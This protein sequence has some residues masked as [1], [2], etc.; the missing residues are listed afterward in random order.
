MPIDPKSPNIRIFFSDEE[1]K[2]DYKIFCMRLK[3]SM[4]GRLKSFVE[5][6]LEY[7]HK[8]G[9]PIDIE[10][11][12]QSKKQSDSEDLPI[13]NTSHTPQQV[14]VIKPRKHHKAYKDK[15]GELVTELAGNQVKVSFDGEEKAFYS[16]ELE[17]V[18]TE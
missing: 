2:I 12:G 8:Y 7:W 3:Q 9:E 5:K 15:V 17:L 14:K 1:T 16:D 18:G 11:I 10:A 4:S 13:T 6:E